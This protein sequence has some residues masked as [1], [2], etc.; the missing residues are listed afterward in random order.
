MGLHGSRLF[1]F[2]T[3]F[4]ISIRIIGSCLGCQ[5]KVWGHWTWSSWD[6]V[7]S[8]FT[9]RS[10]YSMKNFANIRW[11]LLN[12]FNQKWNLKKSQVVFFLQR[13]IRVG[14]D[15]VELFFFL[16]KVNLRLPWTLNVFLWKYKLHRYFGEPGV[17]PWLVVLGCL[18]LWEV[19][20]SKQLSFI[21]DLVSILVCWKLLKFYCFE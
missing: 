14:T 17:Y 3:W 1:F 16:F 6:Q 9:D 8:T 21:D 2:F 5:L 19:S 4:F 11:Y 15:F 18:E 7:S 20:C 10:Q 12:I 13:V